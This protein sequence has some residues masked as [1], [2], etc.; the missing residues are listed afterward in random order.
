MNDPVYT[1][2]A[3]IEGGRD[4]GRGRTP[5]G[6]LDVRLRLPKVLGGNGDGANPEQLFAIG[7]AGCFEA[8]MM[9][10]AKNVGLAGSDVADVAIDAKVML[11]AGDDGTFKL[12]ARLDVELPSVDDEAKA[13]TLIRAAHGLC[14]YS[15]AIRG[16]VD[17]AFTVNGIAVESDSG[18]GAAV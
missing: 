14:P 7:F 4:K 16:N 18:L 13:V 10:A 9:L 6:E 8:V 11:I 1:A 3:R 2:E 15:R 5:G 12:G 17:A